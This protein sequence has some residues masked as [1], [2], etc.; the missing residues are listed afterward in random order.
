MRVRREV[1]RYV[2]AKDSSR[3]LVEVS[4]AAAK[5]IEECNSQNQA[6][7]KLYEGKQFYLKGNRNLSSGE[8]KVSVILDEKSMHGAQIFC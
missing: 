7:L 5:Y 8:C 3:Y 4:P 1:N 2:L 6:I